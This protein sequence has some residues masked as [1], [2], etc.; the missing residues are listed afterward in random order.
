MPQTTELTLSAHM[1]AAVDICLHCYAICEE[2]K[3]YCIKM[4]GR[5]VEA[6][7]LATLADCARMCETS[8]N[9]M[10]RNSDFHGEVCRLCAE[11]C[12]RCA[13]SCEQV[14]RDDE[15][16]RRCAAECRRCAESC[17]QMAA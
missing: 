17:R 7:H 3:A 10:V 1:R 8:A 2:T 11:V 16:M 12:E 4:G 14:D 13:R 6:E 5:H 9:F 15:V